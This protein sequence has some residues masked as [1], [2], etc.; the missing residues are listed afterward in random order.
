MALTSIK[1]NDNNTVILRFAP[2]GAAREAFTR[3]D[4]E[5]VLSGPAGTGKTRALLEKL[6][7]AAAKYPGMRGLM[8]RKTHVALTATALVTY[9][10][11]VLHALDGVQFYGGSMVEAAQFR[12]PNGSRLMVGGMDN[13]MKI[14]SAEYDVA[15][16]NEATELTEDDWERIGTRLRNGAM[17]YQQILA[18]CNPDAPSHWLKKRAD[19]GRCVMLES[20][21]ED[22]PAVTPEYLARLDALTGVRY[23]RLRKGLWAAAEGMVYDGWDRAIHVIDT[24]PIPEEWPRFLSIDFGYTNPFVCQWWAQ[25]PDGRLYLYREIYCT[26]RIVEDHAQAMKAAGLDAP[27]AIICDH[28][29]EDRATL[30]RHLGLRTIAAHKAVS[31]GI[32]AVASRLKVAGDGRPRIF[33]LRDARISPD[34]DLADSKKP[35]AT[36]EEIESYVWDTGGGRKKGEAPVKLDD[37]GADAMRYA[38]AYVDHVGSGG[39][40]FGFV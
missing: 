25:D 3:R 12:Y 4:P 16:V 19:A 6:H 24:F 20:R 11:K 27:R 40:K 10:Q 23:L 34:P 31:P 36:E 15:Y 29:A 8:V 39:G 17:P 26:G 21:H 14:M 35:T 2:H 38:V 1:S 9:Q 7:L 18:D 37:H 28:D 13:A 32:Q 22:N 33:I 5:L 30:E